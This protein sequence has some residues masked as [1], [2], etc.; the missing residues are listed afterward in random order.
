MRTHACLCCWLTM[1]CLPHRHA[2]AT[3]NVMIF[4]F[5]M[6]LADADTTTH[7]RIAQALCVGGV[8]GM[9]CMPHRQLCTYSHQHRCSCGCYLTCCMHK[10]ETPTSPHLSGSKAVAALLDALQDACIAAA[11]KRGVA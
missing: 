2:A 10:H 4:S 9:R 5:I 1:Q 7:C 11:C 6:A 8:G 3:K